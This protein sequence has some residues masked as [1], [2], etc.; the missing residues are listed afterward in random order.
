MLRWMDDEQVQRHFLDFSA[1]V[2][3]L[4][5]RIWDR[6]KWAQSPTRRLAPSPAEKETGV[7]KWR[8]QVAHRMRALFRSQAQPERRRPLASITKAILHGM[9]TDPFLETGGDSAFFPK[10]RLKSAGARM[11][12]RRCF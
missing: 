11:I 5:Y 1:F 4:E 10:V 7:T 12:S 6:K 8:R 3:L 9:R 2:H